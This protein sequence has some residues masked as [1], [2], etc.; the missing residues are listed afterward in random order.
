[1]MLA[2]L[3]KKTFNIKKNLF[4]LVAL[5]LKIQLQCTSVIFNN[6]IS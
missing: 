4:F 2:I 6:L 1:M 5:L 3:A